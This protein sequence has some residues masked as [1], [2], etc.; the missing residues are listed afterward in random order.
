[1]A[2]PLTPRQLLESDWSFVLRRLL[3]SGHLAERLGAKI[4]GLGAFTKIA[5]DRGISVARNLSIPVTTGNSYTAA[6]AVEGLLH[7][8]RLTEAETA[9]NDAAALAGDHDFLPIM[10]ADLAV[11]RL[12]YKTA[13]VEIRK[14]IGGSQ[15]EELSGLYYRLSKL[16]SLRGDRKE[17]LRHLAIARNLAPDLNY[18]TA[19]ELRALVEGSAEFLPAFADLPAGCLQVNFEKGKRALLDDLFSCRHGLGDPSST[20]YIFP[21]DAAP[22]AV[23]TW[24]FFNES[25][26]APSAE[27]RLFLQSL[28]LSSFLDAHGA[29]LRADFTRVQA[30]YGKYRASVAH[31]APLKPLSLGRLEARLDTEHLWARRQGGVVDFRIEEAFYRPGYR[32]T[33]LA[34]PQDSEITDLSV[35]ADEELKQDGWRLLVFYRFLYDHEHFRLKARVRHKRA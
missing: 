18:K 8:G 30:E 29:P 12:D 10:R 23:R 15:E 34:L 35:R 26:L 24:F 21:P 9:I 13:C 31:A 1:L 17:S 4:L 28:P 7:A 19:E 14:S 5:G 2:L 6:T 20:V 33:V 32:T 3:Q 11:L 22:A 25:R 16:Y 27:A